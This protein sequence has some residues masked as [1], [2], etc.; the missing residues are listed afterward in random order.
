MEVTRQFLS[1]VK[2]ATLTSRPSKMYITYDTLKFLGH[3][4]KGDSIMPRTDS[5]QRILNI[6]RPTTKTWVRSLLATVSYYAKF[7]P[8]GS[9]ILSSISDLVKKGGPEKVQWG[10]VQEKSFNC[11]KRFLSDKP[12][13]RLPDM[14]KEFH[15]FIYAN[16]NGIP[17]C[18]RRLHDNKMQPVAFVRRKILP[19]E[20][21]YTIGEKE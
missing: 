2:K 21:N 19:R 12:I 11:L 5:I 6:P 8:H 14:N 18:L 1:R 4:I 9:E 16:N 15:L 3:T 13:F 7:I 20:I 10:E 17:G